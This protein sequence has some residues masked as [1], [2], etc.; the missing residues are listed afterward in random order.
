MKA[1]RRIRRYNHMG[2]CIRIRHGASSNPVHPAGRDCAEL[3]ECKR[4]Y[5]TE[6]F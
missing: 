2:E 6:P 4:Y 1:F 5:I 3:L